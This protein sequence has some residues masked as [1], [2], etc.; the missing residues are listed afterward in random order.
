MVSH[1]PHTY[2]HVL[3]AT[4]MSSYR[5]FLDICVALS[6]PHTVTISISTATHTD[7]SY[8]CATCYHIYVYNRNM[9]AEINP[10]PNGVHVNTF[11]INPFMQL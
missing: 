8:L 9:C 4:Y 1:M 11:H 10:M 5:F 6:S 2:V 7:E 3:A